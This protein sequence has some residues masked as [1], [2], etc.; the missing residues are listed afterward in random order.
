MAY[1]NGFVLTSIRG[2]VGAIERTQSPFATWLWTSTLLV[3]VYLVAVLGALALAHR[4]L[5]RA[6]RTARRILAAA[7]LIVAAGALVGFGDVVASAVYDYHLQ[8]QQ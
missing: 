3:P 1:A 4:R 5:G 6:L 7:A 2:A 8:S